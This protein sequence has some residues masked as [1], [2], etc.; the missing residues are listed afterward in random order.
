MTQLSQT[1]L[2]A[3]LLSRK[4][5]TTSMEIIAACKTV[6]PHRRLT[7]LKNRGWTIVK[8]QVKGKSYH[9]YF[10]TAPKGC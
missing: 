10:G 1:Q 5:G 9:R 3:R 7:D 6:C 8:K 2:L 4:C